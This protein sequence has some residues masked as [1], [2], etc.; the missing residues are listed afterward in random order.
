MATC[1][2]FRTQRQL[3]LHSQPGQASVRAVDREY[4]LL[5]AAFRHMRAR[6]S[7]TIDAAVILPY[8]LHAILFSAEKNSLSSPLRF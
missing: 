7:A 2:Q 4:R 8:H 1:R 5:R 6:Y 3:F